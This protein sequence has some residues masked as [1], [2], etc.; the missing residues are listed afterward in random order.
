[1]NRGELDGQRI[2][3][4]ETYDQLWAE[5]ARHVRGAQGTRGAGGRP[6]PYESFHQD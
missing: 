2:L 6:L 4:T 3:K 5:P 1:M